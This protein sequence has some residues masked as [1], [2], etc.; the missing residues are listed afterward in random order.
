[1]EKENTGKAE[2]VLENIMTR[3]SIRSYLEKP[4]EDSKIRY[5]LQAAMAAPSAKNLQPWSFVVIRSK[6]S[7]NALA[8]ALPYAKMLPKAD[9]AIVVCG[10]ISKSLPI[11]GY[12]AQDASAVSQNIL[13]AAHALG[14]GAVWT[15]VYPRSERIIPVKEILDLPEDIIPLNVIPIGYPAKDYTPRDKWDESKIHYEKW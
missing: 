13:L 14:L 8:D 1:M 2:I 7:L 3:T 4:V 11:E 10:D 15:G 6:E 5:I 12:W 9:V